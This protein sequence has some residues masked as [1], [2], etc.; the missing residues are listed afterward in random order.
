MHVGAHR[1]RFRGGQSRGGGLLHS[2]PD[3]PIISRPPRRRPFSGAVPLAR[4]PPAPCR[5]TTPS[6]TMP[7]SSPV[8]TAE[9]A[10]AIRALAMDAVEAARSGHP[11]MPMGMAEI[12]VALWQRHLRAQPRKPAVAGPRPL[13]P[14]QRP[15]FDAAVRAA[16]PDRLRPPARRAEALPAAALEAPRGI[17]RSASRPVWRRRPGPSG[18]ASPTRSGMALAEKLLAAHFNRPGTRDRRP[19]HLRVRRRRL[20]DGGHFAR[21]LHRSPERWASA[22]SP[23]S[24][25]TTASRSTARSRGWFTDDTPQRFEAYGWNVIRE[26]RRARRRRRRR[27][28]CRGRA[29]VATGRR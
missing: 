26:R 2:S 18:R 22:S 13:R 23:C 25:T 5:C 20:P 3:G 24:T 8:S 15:R 11:G 16:A 1:A 21:G 4:Q 7:T 27:G 17:R 12:A 10:N 29:P 9:L 19:P 28:D 6:P 14:V